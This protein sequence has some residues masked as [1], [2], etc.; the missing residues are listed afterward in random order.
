MPVV[1]PHLSREYEEVERLFEGDALYELPLFEVGEPLVG[2]VVRAELHHRAVA[3]DAC[4][5]RL[6][7]RRVVAQEPFGLLYE[8]F[9]GVP[10]L[11]VEG[12]VEL[13]HHTGPVQRALGY[14]VETLLHLGG[15]SV[16]EY[17]AE[18]LFQVVGHRYPYVFG[19]EFAPLGPEFLAAAL[20]FKTLPFEVYMQRFPF[21]SGAVPNGDVPPVYDGLDGGGVGRGAP[22]SELLQLL[23]EA[24]FAE[25]G[26]AL[27]KCLQCRNPASAELRPHSEPRRE[28]RA[29]IPLLF[30]FAALYIDL[31]ESVEE[32][33]FPHRGEFAVE[34]VGDYRGGGPFYAGVGHLG[35]YG[36]FPDEVV[37]LHLRHRAVYV[38]TGD[39]RGADGLV[40]LLRPLRLC[41]VVARAGVS[42]PVHLCDATLCG[43]QCQRREGGGVGTHIGY[44]P[45]FVEALCGGHGLRDREAQLARRLLLELR[46]GKGGRGG[47]QHLFLLYVGHGETG[48]AARFE[49]GAGLFG[50]FEM[51]V[52]GGLELFATGGE[53]RLHLK[54][55]IAVECG[56]FALP[57]HYETDRYRLYAPRREPPAD[58][59]PQDGGEL[60]TDQAVEDAPGL[61]GL[62]EVHVYLP[63]ILDGMEDGPLGYFVE[64]DPAGALRIEAEGIE[65]VPRNGLPF[66]VFIAREPDGV[67]FAGGGREVGDHLLLIVGH[68]IIG[69]EGAG[70]I[71]RQLPVGQVPDVPVARFYS[72]FLTEKFF[73]RLGFCRRFDNY[74]ILSHIAH[75][76]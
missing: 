19:E 71:Y 50:R 22:D 6:S 68:H 47:A 35:G 33:F 28:Y 67:G 12:A 56:D 39:V 30:I 25:T 60:V 34:A 59:P 31:H 44:K 29:R 58:F 65:E 62:D 40:C 4:R 64:D 17:V 55:C 32:A 42:G 9:V 10:R 3:G 43:G 52:E 5:D 20:L 72:K 54:I 57:V 23:Y 69:L 15:K 36:P 70:R 45:R 16:V 37:E 13:A 11:F 21:A 24:R 26:G 41:L 46:G 53:D 63:R 27:R 18:I 73:N 48:V 51:V 38:R 14:E 66:A 7:A 75:N 49:E 8:P 61:L 1:H 2:V 76:K 74:Q